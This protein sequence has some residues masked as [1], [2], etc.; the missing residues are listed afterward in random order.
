MLPPAP[1]AFI[2]NFQEAKE[3]LAE[4]T[5]QA[6]EK[7]ASGVKELSERSTRIALNV[8]FNAPLIF[9]PQSSTSTNVIVADLGRLSVRNRFAKQPYKSN[10]AIPPVVDIMA[11][12]LTDLKMYRSAPV[13]LSIRRSLCGFV[14]HFQTSSTRFLNACIL[15]GARM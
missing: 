3:A 12:K 1:Q 5:V 8:H 14:D 4:V 6:A 2:N 7:A 13:F 11:V 15:L 9:M 10:A